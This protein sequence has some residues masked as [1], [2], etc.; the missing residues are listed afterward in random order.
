VVARRPLPGGPAGQTRASCRPLLRAAFG[1]V[2][3]HVARAYRR[4]FLSA[5]Q[6][7]CGLL[8]PAA[9]P[10]RSSCSPPEGS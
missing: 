8:G 3:D 2:P 9:G 10:V 5:P 7:K 1:H 4:A 6:P